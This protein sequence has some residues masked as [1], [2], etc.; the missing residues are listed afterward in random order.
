[1]RTALKEREREVEALRHELADRDARLVAMEKT[2]PPQAEVERMEAEL[3]Q[4]RTR[5]GEI[6][7]ELERREA[8]VDRAAAAAAHERARAERLVAEERRAMHD[9]NE[10][11]A[12]AAAAEA[13]I[14]GLTDALERGRLKEEAEGERARK[15]ENEVRERKERVKQL[16]REL[17]DAERRAQRA[18]GID[19]VR[20]RL[21][22]MESTLRGEEQRMALIEDALRRAATEADLPSGLEPR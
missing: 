1:M 10:A 4:A 18:A 7:L 6:G 9:R 17:E 15:A 3:A 16:K 11:R 12:R 14:A 13:K 8:A 21:E 22:Q 20:A 19:A 2:H 5:L